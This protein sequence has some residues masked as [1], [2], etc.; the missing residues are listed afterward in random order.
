MHLAK[1]SFLPWGKNEKL[2]YLEKLGNIAACGSLL[3][4]DRLSWDV[5]MTV[6]SVEGNAHWTPGEKCKLS[7]ETQLVMKDK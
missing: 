7:K 6:R 2:L 1:C 5:V 3:K 4:S